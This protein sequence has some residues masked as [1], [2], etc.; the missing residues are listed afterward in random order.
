MVGLSDQTVNY[1]R[2]AEVY[3]AI[4]GD[5]EGVERYAE[6]LDKYL[7]GRKVLDL[8]C[9]TGDLT[10]A[11]HKKGYRMTGLDLS[12]PMLD[13]TAAKFHPDSIRLFCL[14]ML[15]FNLGETFDSIICA[16]DSVNYCDSLQQYEALF[17]GVNCHLTL[18]GTF[19]FDVH[20]ESRLKEF[21][22]PFEESGRIG[23]MGYQW[24]IES[25]PPVLRHTITIYS[26]GY[27]VIE[28][29]QQY[30]FE[31]SEI[32]SLLSQCGF[33]WEIIDPKKINDLYL[34]EK[35]L[36]CATKERNL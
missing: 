20:M 3:D 35:Y 2:L 4:M 10:L 33:R 24:L 36:I 12:Q 30:I 22:E 19:F 1:G 15:N 7:H 9:G 31:I 5:P 26:K 14:D 27:P 21:S 6:M 34:N 23:Q 18:G 8:A 16:N 17:Y 32:L 11:L 29:H 25:E 28:T 13:I